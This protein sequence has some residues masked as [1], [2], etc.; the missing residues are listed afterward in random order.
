[1]ALSLFSRRRTE[2]VVA[3]RRPEPR[4]V[5]PPAAYEPAEPMALDQDPLMRLLQL[6]RFGIVLARQEQ[7][8]LHPAQR[9]CVESAARSVDEHFAPFFMAGSPVAL[10]AGSLKVIFTTLS[11]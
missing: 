7:W 9:G 5:A 8:H 1:M 2:P 11:R 3:E 4:P 6:E 10:T